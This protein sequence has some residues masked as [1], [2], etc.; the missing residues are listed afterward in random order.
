[1]KIVFCHFTSEFSLVIEADQGINTVSVRITRINEG[2]CR[3]EVL[4]TC[5]G[6][7]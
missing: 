6:G 3:A 4:D 1:M 7:E 2:V 5:V